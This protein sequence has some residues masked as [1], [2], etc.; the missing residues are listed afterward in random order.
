MKH[1]C[2]V[3][4]FNA[5]IY[6]YYLFVDCV[7]RYA[8]CATVE[9]GDHFHVQP[10]QHVLLF[11]FYCCCCAYYYNSATIFKAIRTKSK[12]GYS[13]CDRASRWCTPTAHLAPKP[14][15]CV[16][17]LPTKCEYYVCMAGGWA[18]PCTQSVHPLSEF[19]L[20]PLSKSMAAYNFVFICNSNGKSNEWNGYF[21]WLLIYFQFGLW[22][23]P[24]DYYHRQ[25]TSAYL[26][27][28]F[29]HKGNSSMP[30]NCR[31]N[32]IYL[33]WSWHRRPSWSLHRPA[34]RPFE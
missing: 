34:F 11:W 1:V 5:K 25:T 33:F 15:R 30:P 13:I 14:Y 8:K 18:L 29:L 19:N 22:L 16:V 23:P 28:I 7:N 31:S 9:E 12:C 4:L 2:W 27:N 10:V 32:L 17:H 24:F 26:Y 20:F 3:T 21:M 6:L